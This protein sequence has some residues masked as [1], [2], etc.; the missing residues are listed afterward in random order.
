MTL[1]NLLYVGCLGYENAG[2][3][4]CLEGARAVLGRRLG[5]GWRLQAVDAYHLHPGEA[6]FDALVLGGGTL[7]SPRGHIGDDAMREARR[8]GVPYFIFGTGLESPEWEGWPDDDTLRSFTGLVLGAAAIGVRGPLSREY[9]VRAGVPAGRVR[10]VGDLAAG[11]ELGHAHPRRRR[12]GPR[13]LAVNVGTSFGRVW[14]GDEEAMAE[15]LIRAL[16]RLAE[17]GWAIRLF[18]VWPRD[19]EMQRRVASALAGRAGV[20]SVED[21]LSPATL[22][23]SLRDAD[24]VIAMK[25]HAG[26]FS[27]LAGVPYVPWSYRPK[28]EDFAAAVG[29]EPYV[30]RTDR[31]AEALLAA[32]DALARRRPSVR[33]KMARRIRGM[34]KRLQRFADGIVGALE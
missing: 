31:P 29:L 20:E 2:D 3:E 21:V 9:L 22:V 17:E 26:I 24:A 12:E 1:R 10:V 4:A 5:A 28:V 7:L 13:R 30:V 27:A 8:R 16:D 18:P 32:L 14:G 25:L 11:M 6:P 15:E 34:R 19:L 33:R 23:G